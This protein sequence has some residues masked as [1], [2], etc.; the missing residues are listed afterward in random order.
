MRTGATA[1]E[2]APAP[3]PDPDP[4]PPAWVVWVAGCG[5]AVAG[6]VSPK[7]VPSRA[8]GEATR[9]AVKVTVAALA[10]PV[11]VPHTGAGLLLSVI[12]AKGEVAWVRN[13]DVDCV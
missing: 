7:K 3:A 11:D 6:C 8:M 2:V 4:D 5:S 13:I 10:C 9:R 1:A 12:L